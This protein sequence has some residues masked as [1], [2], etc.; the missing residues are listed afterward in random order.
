MARSHDQ[1]L[2]AKLGFADPDRSDP[3]H[4][5]ACRYLATEPVL[6][7]LEMKFRPRK[8]VLGLPTA[9]GTRLTYSYKDEGY[10]A[11]VEFERVISKGKGDFR[12]LVGL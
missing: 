2:L 8:T 5:F 1:T 10:V 6:E 9:R 12:V 4:D 11:K 7:Q 3:T